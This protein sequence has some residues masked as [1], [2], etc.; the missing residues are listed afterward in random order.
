MGVSGGHGRRECAGGHGGKIKWKYGGKTN[1]KY[2]YGGKTRRENTEGQ[3]GDK[4]HR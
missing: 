2:M 3:Q 4:P 1:W